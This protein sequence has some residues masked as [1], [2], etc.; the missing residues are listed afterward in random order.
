[1]DVNQIFALPLSSSNKN[2]HKF[3]KIAIFVSTTS[4]GLRF[5]WVELSYICFNQGSPTQNQI[6]CQPTSSIGWYTPNTGPELIEKQ[7]QERKR[8]REEKRDGREGRKEREDDRDADSGH[9]RAMET[10]K[11]SNHGGRERR[12]REGGRGEEEKQKEGEAGGGY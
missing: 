4:L 5:S 10:L 11:W 6:P 8:T 2:R 3:E 7:K 1:M 12:K 9:P